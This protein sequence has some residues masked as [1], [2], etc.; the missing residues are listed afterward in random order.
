[1]LSNK[2]IPKTKFYLMLIFTSILIL[3]ISLESMFRAKDVSFF[4]NWIYI[5]NIIIDNEID[6]NQAFNS[7]LVVI[8]STMFIKIVIPMAL[9]LYSYFAYT[10]IGINRMFI[11]IWSVLLLGGLGYELVGF[12][13]GSIFFYINII[14]YISLIL[15]IFSL[16]SVIDKSK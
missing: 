3:S 13:I 11:F 16:N 2:R 9:S 4:E 5:N 8:L 12:N 6:L 14:V 7:Y 1:M 10:R 15:I